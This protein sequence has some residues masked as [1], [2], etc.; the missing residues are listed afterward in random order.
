MRLSAPRRLAASVGLESLGRATAVVSSS[1]A[2]SRIVGLFSSLAGAAVLGAEDFGRF[3]FLLVTGSVLGSLGVMGLGPLIT[4]EIAAAKE[5]AEAKQVAAFGLKAAGAL[6]V[7]FA[8]A[9]VLLSPM[10]A[11]TSIPLLSSTE[12]AL[13]TAGWGALLGLNPIAIAVFVGYR[14]FDWVGR[15]TIFRAVVVGLLTVFAAQMFG[16]AIMAAAGALAGEAISLCV[17]LAV[18]SRARLAIGSL[19]NGWRLG[20]QRLAKR[21]MGAGAASV[22]IQLAMWLTQVW[23]LHRPDGFS[24][25]GGFMVATRLVLVITFLPNAI[26]MALLPELSESSLGSLRRQQLK[27][28]A[29]LVAVAVGA[30]VAIL[31]IVT[32]PPFIGLVLG[33]DF[34]SYGDTAALMCIGG[35]VVAANNVLGS[36]AVADGR[37]R[38]WIWSDV[39]LAVVVLVIGIWLVVPLGANGLA[40][41]H[42][43]G[44]TVSVGIL[45]TALRTKNATVR[46]GVPT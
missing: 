25:N 5:T 12:A 42:L 28:R 2:I 1:S 8:C 23:L 7:S 14:R 38:I 39:A 34:R 11:K 33:N 18:I 35:I 43:A 24:E 20:G 21:A 26:A 19:A 22:C 4:R 29:V 31:G 40:L 30:L 32:I 13:I 9:Y 27:V 3:A 45:A 17:A 6:L 16:T 37:F 46:V 44:Y 36:C 41:A 15:L 10:L